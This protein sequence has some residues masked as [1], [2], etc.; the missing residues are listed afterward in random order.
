MNDE[1]KKAA[2]EKAL[3]LALL[4]LEK[5]KAETMSEAP[6]SRGNGGWWPF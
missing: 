5:L 2:K 1:E 4:I 3:A 6:V